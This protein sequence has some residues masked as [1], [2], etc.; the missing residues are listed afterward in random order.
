M[1]LDIYGTTGIVFPSWTTR[2]STPNAGEVG[3]NSSL[4]QLE[5][6]NGTSWVKMG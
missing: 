1:S 6:Y 3:F 4:V 2:P 5:F